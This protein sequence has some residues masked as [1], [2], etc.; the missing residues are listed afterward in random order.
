MKTKK[1]NVFL[2]IAVILLCLVLVSAHF[3]AGIFAKMISNANG[4]DGTGTARF[5]VDAKL[6][7]VGEKGAYQLELINNSDTAVRCSV[8]I[9]LTEKADGTIQL[10]DK[11]VSFTNTDSVQLDGTFTLAP[12][13]NSKS[14]ELAVTLTDAPE[15]EEHFTD[16]SNDTTS[17]SN[18]EVPFT[19]IVS[20]VQ[21]D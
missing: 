16:R 10:G 9:V 7:D 6:T 4:S 12:H 11:T 2:S 5:Q 17:G 3:T 1:P 21:V 18:A 20:A 15:A 14:M 19:V 8:K 13:T